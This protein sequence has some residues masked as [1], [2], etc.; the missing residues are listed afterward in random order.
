ML[1]RLMRLEYKYLVAIVFIFGLFMDMI[2]STVVNVAIP[3][4]VK[5]FHSTN[6]SVEWTATAYLLS[7]AIFI[8][9]SGFLSDRFGTK[10]TFLLA[11]GVFTFFSACCGFS[12]SLW[13]LILFRFLQ[14]MGG[15]MMTPVSTAILSR[16]FPGEER[17]KASAII[18]VPV[19][20]APVLGPVLGGY[21]VEYASWR[22]IFFIN[23][24]IGIIGMF[25]SWKILIEHKESYA[26]GRFDFAGLL[27]GG[28]S[29]ALILYSLA[30]AANGSLTSPRVL[31]T[32]L[33]GLTALTVFCLWELHTD[34]PLLDLR[35][36][37]S[38]LFTLG[39]I[40]VV[41]AFAGFSGFLFLLALYLQDLQGHDALHAGLIQAPS[42]FGTVISLPLASRLYSRVGPRRLMILGFGLGAAVLL[43]F[44]WVDQNT[45]GLTIIIL[46]TL[47]GLPFGFGFVAAQT[48]VYGP[49]AS[50][51]QGPASSIYNTM[52][53]MFASFG[54]ALGAT[55]FVSRTAHYAHGIV[56]PSVGAQVKGYHE[57][58]MLTGGLLLISTVAAFFVSDKKARESMM[59][60]VTSVG[61]DGE[62]THEAMALH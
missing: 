22:W 57:G 51:K 14:G 26:R 6:Q 59:R 15:G 8:P 42:A 18:S 39:N 23:L 9:S 11:M 41:G 36:F 12:Q 47:R 54:V 20:F 49:L 10:K 30:D 29:S 1:S 3:T 13:Q 37:K 46:L 58:F 34:P 53:Q 55:V 50:D 62:E 44:A 19:V 31:G 17:A 43:P 27:L 24:P 5:D 38:S 60:R 4:L 2:D 56:P 32:G 21:L 45:S 40:G 7:L 16:A 33:A 35:L 61:E 48:I 52:R 25:M 28:M